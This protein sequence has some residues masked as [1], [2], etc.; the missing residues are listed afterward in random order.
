A[1]SP[2]RNLTWK[3]WQPLNQNLRV[4][5]RSRPL[6]LAVIG[7]AFFTF[8]TLFA[9]QTLLYEGETEKDHQAARRELARRQAEA[10]ADADDEDADIVMA[11]KGASEAQTAEIRV[12]ILI[13]LIGLGVGIGSPLAGALSGNKVE[14]G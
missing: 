5:L 2:E 10:A 14:L 6:A 1:A 7:I 3:L 12:A 9:R 8:I 11:P 13:A 4:M